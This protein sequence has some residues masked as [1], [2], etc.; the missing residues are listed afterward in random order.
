MVLSKKQ[1][2]KQS[3]KI[4]K[5]RNDVLNEIKRNERPLVPPEIGENHENSPAIDKIKPKKTVNKKKKV[6][7]ANKKSVELKKISAPKP[8]IRKDAS[9][10]KPIGKIKKTTTAK[11]IFILFFFG[12]ILGCLL[13]AA[14][15]FYIPKTES[16]PARKISKIISFPAI[17]IN[18]KFI[19]YNNY[20]KEV[21]TVDL[22]L[23]RQKRIGVIQEIPHRKQIR[24]EIA[25]LLIRQ[26]IIKNLADEYKISVSQKEIDD[27]IN[28]IKEKSRSEESFE[29]MLK[30]LYGWSEEDFGNKVIQNYLLISK[31]SDKMFPDISGEESK[32]LFDKKIE[33][34]KQ[35]MNIYVL[36][37]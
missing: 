1:I 35:G 7:N 12:I 34:L 17:I 10:A 16:L 32:E 13:F 2:K 21:D 19:S 29:G 4:V 28:K 30:N 18:G 25:N 3:D 15:V 24:K 9:A 5:M 36:I 33:E 23:T 27:E 22:F 14:F 26:E 31:L 11:N 37:E 20:L 6:I 8:M